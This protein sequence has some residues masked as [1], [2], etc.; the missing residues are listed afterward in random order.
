MRNN[1]FTLL[2]LSIVIVIIGL[3]VAGIS[4]GQSLVKSAQARSV[5]SESEQYKVALNTFRL[6][7]GHNNLPGDFDQANSYWP[8]CGNG[9]AAVDCNG[10]GDS[11]I[12][13]GSTADDFEQLRAWQHLSLAGLIDGSYAGGGTTDNS[14]W[15]ETYIPHSANNKSRWT[16]STQ[17]DRYSFNGAALTFR[18]EHLSLSLA[19][20]SPETNLAA[21]LTVQ[22]AFNLDKKVDDGVANTGKLFGLDGSFPDPAAG[23]CSAA[24]NSVGGADYNTTSL[25]DDTAYCRM[26]F[27]LLR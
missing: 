16:L 15:D 18:K 11:L 6:Q 25:S 20:K 7:Y 23:S 24:D 2:E 14:Q 12:S 27:W 13:R 22:E 4:A 3:I 17:R 10:D 9:A 1:G 19:A 21:T 5:I 26:Q 8:G